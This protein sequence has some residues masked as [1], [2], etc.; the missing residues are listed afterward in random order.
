MV[1]I[2]AA[3]TFQTLIRRQLARI[4]PG[5][6]TAVQLQLEPSE[7][8]LMRGCMIGSNPFISFRYDTVNNDSTCGSSVFHP[9]SRCSCDIKNR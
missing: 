2:P 8:L 6:R 7:Q 1:F 9:V 4:L 3:E 5:I